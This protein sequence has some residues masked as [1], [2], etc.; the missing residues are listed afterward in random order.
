[1]GGGLNGGPEGRSLVESI[2]DLVEALIVDIQRGGSRLPFDASARRVLV[3]SVEDLLAE[4][5]FKKTTLWPI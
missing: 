2:V 4:L 5:A 3:R 1:M